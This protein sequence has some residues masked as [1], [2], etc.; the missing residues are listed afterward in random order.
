MFSFDIRNPDSSPAD[1][2]FFASLLTILFPHLWVVFLALCFSIVD[3]KTTE[4]LMDLYNDSAFFQYA[5]WFTM[6]VTRYRDWFVIVGSAY[7]FI[8]LFRH[9]RVALKSE[10]EITRVLTHWSTAGGARDGLS[11]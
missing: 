8:H 5:M 11:Q 7:L 9:M 1:I 6:N 3:C 10:L 2:P 4:C